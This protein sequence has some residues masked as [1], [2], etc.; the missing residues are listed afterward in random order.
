MVVSP[1]LCILPSNV[2]GIDFQ[3]FFESQLLNSHG[4][5]SKQFKNKVAPNI[6]E[7]KDKT[8]GKAYSLIHFAK[9][10]NL[11]GKYEV[12]PLK[13]AAI[14]AFDRRLKKCSEKIHRDY[15]EFLEVLKYLAVNAQLEDDIGYGEVN[16]A[17]LLECLMKYVLV[18]L[19]GLLQEDE[20][21]EIVLEHSNVGLALMKVLN[22]TIIASQ[23]R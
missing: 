5:I 4:A 16:S 3:Y 11:A 17:T 20:F 14:K 21:E 2:Q 23:G 8:T 18:E 12:Q 10:F 22:Q 1:L 13:I 6:L 15:V 9:V 19:G 7:T